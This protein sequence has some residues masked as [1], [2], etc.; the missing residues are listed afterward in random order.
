MGCSAQKQLINKEKEGCNESYNIRVIGYY[1]PLRNSIHIQP[2]CIKFQRILGQIVKVV[3]PKY[4]LA[5]HKGKRLLV[6]IMQPE[7][8]KKTQKILITFHHMTMFE[9]QIII[10]F[11]NLQ[12]L[13]KKIQ[14]SRQKSYLDEF[15]RYL[16]LHNVVDLIT[17]QKLKIYILSIKILN[18]TN[19]LR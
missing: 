10:K 15:S 6:Q 18:Q 12:I 17:C 7:Q 8:I 9:L 3:Q 19:V 14:T 11:H 16:R 13:K 5:G 4:I 1:Y 2:I